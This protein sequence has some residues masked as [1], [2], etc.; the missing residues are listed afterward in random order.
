M[1]SEGKLEIKK[2]DGSNFQ[3]WKFNAKLVLMQRGLWSLVSGSEEAPVATATDKKEKEIKEYSLR[4]QKAYSLIALSVC[5]NLQIHVVDTVDPKTAWDNLEKQFNFVSITQTVRVNRK[6]YAASMEEGGNLIEHITYMTSLSHRL[7]EMGEYVNDK[8]FATVLLGSLPESYD[9]FITSLNARDADKM[10]WNEIKPA[11]VEEFMKRTEKGQRQNSEDAMFTRGGGGGRS[12][13]YPRG[14]GTSFHGRGGGPSHRG[15]PPQNFANRGGY[16][17]GSEQRQCWKCKDF[18]HIARNC[19]SQQIQQGGDREEGNI[20]STESIKRGFAESFLEVDMAL[21]TCEKEEAFNPKRRRA[22]ENEI[23]DDG[24][25]E[26]RVDSTNDRENEDVF[27][28]EANES[29]V[30]VVS[31]ESDVAL[32][33]TDA[34]VDAV[35]VWFIDSAASAHMTCSKSNLFDFKSFVDPSTGSL[36]PREI[37]LGN[38]SSIYATGE[39]KTI[40]KIIDEKNRE[41]HMTLERVLFVPDLAKNLLSVPAVTSKGAIVSFHDR[42]CVISKG[43]VT[44]TLGYRVGKS[45]L[46]RAN[47]PSIHP[48]N[49]NEIANNEFLNTTQAKDHMC[50]NP[51]IEMWHRRFGHLNYKYVE[52]MCKD[53]LVSGMNFCQNAECSSVESRDCE[54][55]SLGK[56]QRKSLPKK[57]D[58]RATKVFEIV[59]TDICGPMQVDSAGG[60]RYILTFTDDF[61]RYTTVYVLKKKSEALNKFKHYVNLI[62]NQ[63]EGKKITNLYIWNHLK[64]VRSDNGGEYCSS[65]FTEFCSSKGISHQFTNPY[66]PEQNGVAERYNRFLIESVRSMLILSKCPLYLWAEA[67]CT[68]VYLHNRSPTVA[69]D[70]KTPYEC[71]HGEKPDVSVLKVFGCVCHY[72]IP[73]ELRKKLDPPSRKAVFVGYPEDTKGYKIF[74]PELKKFYR[75]RNVNFFEDKFYDFSN[76]TH[77]SANKF[78]VFPLDIDTQENGDENTNNETNNLSENAI[79]DVDNLQEIIENNLQEMNIQDRQQVGV[80]RQ[81]DQNVEQVVNEVD[82]VVVPP[83]V[84]KTYEE[85]FMRQVENIPEKRIRKPKVPFD[86]A[87]SAI[88]YE[89]YFT[90]LTSEICEPKN[91]KEALSGNK[92]QEWRSAMD[93]EYDSLMKNKTWT[94]VPRPPNANV[95]GNRW[96]FKIKRRGD[97]SIDRYKARFVAQGFTQTH[98][99][100]YDEVFSPVARGSAIRCLLALANSNDWEIHQMDVKTAFLNGEL[101]HDVYMEQPPGY[102]DPNHPDYVC[103]LHKSLYG[104]KQSARC[105]NHTLDQFLKSQGYIQGGADGCIYVKIVPGENNSFLIFVVYVDDLLPISNDTE[106]LKKEKAVLCEKYEMTDN[107]EADYLLGMVIKR[108]RTSRTLTMS[109]PTYLRDMLK[110]FRMENCNAVGTPTDPA[111]Q[112]RRRAQDE[113]AFDKQTYQ[114]AIGCLTYTSTSTR[115]DIAAAL[116]LLSQYMSDPSE[117]HWTGVKRLFRYI[118]GTL[119]YGLTFRQGDNVLFGYSDADWAGCLDTRR[120]TSGYVFKVC[121]A[122]ISWMSKKQQTV[123]KSTTEAEYVA[124]GMAVQET[125]WLRRLLGDIG[126]QMCLPTVVYEDNNGAI[127]LSRNAKHHTRTKHIDITHH[128]TRERVQAGEVSVVPCPTDDMVADVMTKGLGRVKF[129]KFRDAMGVF[130]C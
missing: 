128:F 11:L 127:D 123:A 15:G 125:I 88:T 44:F 100:D 43:D 113:P 32:M 84:E 33:T 5:E 18:G 85:T 116:G 1:A 65:E 31:I 66:T 109:Q 86:E 19:R 30:S 72:Q 40:I 24:E 50:K 122:T 36:C 20:A 3:S 34:Q 97:G 81:V 37:F 21:I 8:K 35:D 68:A 121:D 62:E 83:Q 17:G 101:D 89:A 56:M 9:T 70:G 73:S 63:T 13:Y 52:K 67:V 78:C 107:G 77:M 23:D 91:V 111:A 99:I 14:R 79:N 7:K 47:T 27:L 71:W 117:S 114:Q 98:G 54:A 92:K 129:Q 104:L 42:K 76:E 55:C 59:H 6:F 38:D 112:Y 12:G 124:L 75:S 110:K 2:L 25:C 57:S 105:W 94:L 4:S 49:V 93:S 61:S 126:Y 96:I 115:P 53:K 102:I 26:T 51:S 10:S 119:D 120:S 74:D 64:T 16:V 28:D 90:S 46:Y 118:R 80:Q 108:D 130:G 39:G 22:D 69:L 82:N 29:N 60:S 45:K 103:K 58:N 41:R 106:M 87:H 48:E 95:V